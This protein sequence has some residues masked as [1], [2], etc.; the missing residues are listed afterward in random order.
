MTKLDLDRLMRLMRVY[1]VRGFRDWMRV[2][3]SKHRR[4]VR[5]LFPNA[6]VENERDIEK[7]IGR[8]FDGENHRELL[9][10]MPECSSGDVDWCFFLPMTSDQEQKVVLRFFLLIKCTGD[11]WL[12]FRFEMGGRTTRHGYGHIQFS[13]SVPQAVAA[14]GPAWLPCKDPAF[15]TCARDSFELFLAMVMAVHGFPG[16]ADTLLVDIFQN[17]S[18]AKP[19]KKRLARMLKANS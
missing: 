15:P 18:E 2:K 5:A 14:L 13:R 8:V 16:G 1:S 4:S 3:K 7:T 6:V 11:N 12:T 10:P 19:Y 17:A 9:V